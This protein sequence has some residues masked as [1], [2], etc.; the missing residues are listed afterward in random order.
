[1]GFKSCC[2][3]TKAFACSCSYGEANLGFRLGPCKSWHCFP[4]FPRVIYR[5]TVGIGLLDGFSLFKMIRINTTIVYEYSSRS[6][7]IPI[8]YISVSDFGSWMMSQTKA[9]NLRR[10]RIVCCTSESHAGPRACQLPSLLLICVTC[11]V[12]SSARSCQRSQ[13]L[14]S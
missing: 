2:C 4:P 1:M 13:S 5:R 9:M 14:S 3:F 11:L 7:R 12:T 10:V 6:L 8:G